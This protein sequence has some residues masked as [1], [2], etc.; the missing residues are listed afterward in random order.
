[1]CPICGNEV[2]TLRH[3]M[4]DCP[5]KFTFWNIALPKINAPDTITHADIWTAL[6]LKTST[7]HHPFLHH[8][9]DALE[10]I[11]QTIWAMHW[12]TVIDGHPW[13]FLIAESHL[14][15]LISRS[16]FIIPNSTL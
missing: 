4:L 1:M 13:S 6:Q 5:L 15:N 10:L 14:D 9:L 8:H 3:F 11:F 7:L 16:P 2:E 12:R